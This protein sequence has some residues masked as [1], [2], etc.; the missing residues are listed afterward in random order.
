[1]KITDESDP[2][3]QAELGGRLRAARIGLNLSQAAVA[4]EAGISKRSL[5]R[6]EAGQTTTL[7]SFLRLL[8]HFG[9]LANLNLLIPDPDDSPILE[10]L[11]RSQKR[12]RASARHGQG[13]L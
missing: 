11:A 6:I 4:R 3:I 9:L 13:S 1:M 10:V 12:L 8:R 2:E 7:T 5:E